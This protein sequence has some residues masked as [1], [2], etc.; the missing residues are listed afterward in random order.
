M[1]KRNYYKIGAKWGSNNT[2]NFYGVMKKNKVIIYND[3][4]ELKIGDVG[5]VAK[6]GGANI[7]DLGIVISNIEEFSTNPPLKSE[8]DAITPDISKCCS[9]Y[10][11]EWIDISQNFYGSNYSRQGLTIINK[12]DAISEIDKRI[13]EYNNKKMITDI[14]KLVE[15]NKNLIFTGAPGTGKTFTAKDVA[16]QMIFKTVSS[17]KKE[18]AEKLKTSPQFKLVQFHP[19]YTYEDFVRGVVVETTSGTP[20]YKTVNKTLGEFAKR[21]AEDVDKKPY[22]LIIDEINRAN[23]PAVLGEL[24]YALEYRGETVESM[25][26]LDDGNNSLM[27]PENLFII[28]T[29]NT[30]DRSVGQIDYAIRR[31]FAFVE[32]LP[33]DLSDSLPTGKTFESD[34][35]KQVSALFIK[36]VNTYEAD[37]KLEKSDY[38]S[39][40]FR[41]EDVWIGHSYF[42]TDDK[43]TKDYRL[44]YEI[45]PILKEYL[46]DGILTS[47]A[48]DKINELK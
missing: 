24:I 28:G 31:R 34:L 3:S 7:T 17:D 1:A 23:L 43:K 9:Y 16:E 30:A 26:K 39:A 37:S 36:N 27:L 11:V 46:K 47:A 6:D 4:A 38:L 29:M 32:C 35:F 22:V 14:L 12:P 18:Q 41:P 42:I 5:A 45:K 13:N 8:F 15:T 20:T 44:K 19:A 10:K 25:Y 21:A 40:E 33:K 48:E 2:Y